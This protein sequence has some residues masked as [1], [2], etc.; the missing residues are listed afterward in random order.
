MYSMYFE[1]H[2]Y[3]SFVIMLSLQF[4][5]HPLGT[6]NLLLSD[7]FADE[8]FSSADLPYCKGKVPCQYLDPW[9]LNWPRGKYACS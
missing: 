3:L 6:V 5:T 7:D 8:G 4:D 9:D 1:D 2:N